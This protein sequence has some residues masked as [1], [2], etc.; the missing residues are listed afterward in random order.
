MFIDDHVAPRRRIGRPPK[1]TD[2][3]L[4][5]LAVAQV[6]LGFP[7]ARHWIRFAHAR[8]GHLFRYR[9][10]TSV[11][12]LALR[13][14]MGLASSLAPEG[15]RTLS[16]DSASR[17]G[18]WPRTRSGRGR[19]G[20]RSRRGAWCRWRPCRHAGLD[21]LVVVHREVLARQF[22]GGPERGPWAAPRVGTG[23]EV[24]QVQVNDPGLVCFLTADAGAEADGP[25]RTPRVGGVAAGPSVTHA[26]SLPVQTP[27]ATSA[28]H[29]HAAGSDDQQATEGAVRDNSA[30]RPGGSQAAGRAARGRL[31][32]GRADLPL[33]TGAG[34]AGG[35]D[36]RRDGGRR[37]GGRRLV[38]AGGPPTRASAEES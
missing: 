2:A 22:H 7:S 14:I 10:C 29:Q 35:G 6:L 23:A 12:R 28:K 37:G 15:R 5:C 16:A 34:R 21:D 25:A 27:A 13:M 24:G 36:N 38:S 11:Q 8:L 32:D 9:A 31:A 30:A 1:L 33:R 19:P 3:E 20:G 17:P 4:L 26:V 18:P